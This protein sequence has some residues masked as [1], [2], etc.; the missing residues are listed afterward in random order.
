MSICGLT[1]LDMFFHP[2]SQP[3]KSL[4]ICLGSFKGS[5]ILVGED[6]ALFEVPNGFSLVAKQGS[7][8]FRH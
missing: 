6:S 7:T 4:G 3:G 1:N 5:N 2:T 8:V